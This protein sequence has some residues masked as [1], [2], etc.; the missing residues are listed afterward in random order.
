VPVS[1]LVRSLSAIGEDTIAASR[2]GLAA[3]VQ[4]AHLLADPGER[5]SRLAGWRS[6]GGPLHADRSDSPRYP[7]QENRSAQL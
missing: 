2:K 7:A 4:V 6:G 5:R 1:G 3:E